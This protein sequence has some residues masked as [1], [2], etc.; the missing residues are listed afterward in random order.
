MSSDGRERIEEL[1]NCRL[2]TAHGDFRLSIWQASK[3]VEIVTVGMGKLAGNN[4]LF[5]RVHSQ[6]FT[7]EVLGSLRCDCRPQLDSALEKI[8]GLQRGLLIYLQQ[9]GR[10]IG[11]TNKIRAYALQDGGADTL[12]ANHLLGFEDDLRDFTDAGRLLLQEG[13]PSIRLNTNNPR[14]IQA[15][16]DCGVEIAEVIP[17]L[18]PPNPHNSRYLET[19]ALRMGHLFSPSGELPAH[20]RAESTHKGE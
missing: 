7:S 12:E 9:E 15:L 8:G 17:S 10:G 1:A 20:P 14:K 3:G 5:V 4:P 19:K 2:P 18:S 13:I 6:C 16:V 11:L